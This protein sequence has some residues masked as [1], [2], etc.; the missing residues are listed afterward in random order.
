M[1]EPFQ[2]VTITLIY[3]GF[4]LFVVWFVV[5]KL[6]FSPTRVIRGVMRE[7][8]AIAAAPWS[9]ASLNGIGFIFLA[10]L[11]VFY[12]V[13]DRVRQLL[14]LL[15]SA[16]GQHSNAPFEFVVAWSGLAVFALLSVYSLPRSG[17]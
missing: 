10:T 6:D 1:T 17:D 16:T 12:F 7:I 4:A 13:L 14:D 9:R 15:H 3:G 8:P 11:L 2:Q 5:K